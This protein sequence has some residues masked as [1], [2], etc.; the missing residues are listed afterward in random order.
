[1]VHGRDLFQVKDRRGSRLAVDLRLNAPLVT[2]GDHRRPAPCAPD[3]P[4]HTPVPSLAVLLPARDIWTGWAILAYN[5][6]TLAIH[7][8]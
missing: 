1:V 3:V 6:D 8:T 5:L 2:V 7:T 4:R